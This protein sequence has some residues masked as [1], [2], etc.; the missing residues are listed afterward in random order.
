M[1]SQSPHLL[2]FSVFQS[3]MPADQ[4]YKAHLSTQETLK[5]SG[6]PYIPVQGAYKGVKELG[7]IVSADQRKVV[8][9][10][11]KQYNQ[12]SYLEHH[13]DRYCE[14]ICADGTSK[15]LGTM[16]ETTKDKAEK[17]DAYTL[18]PDGRYFVV[19]E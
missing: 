9:D 10:I 1:K 13:N 14:L 4:N 7:F 18:T 11:C 12:E 19:E 16:V 3:N 15:P 17:S 8:D 6:I 2:I 5:L